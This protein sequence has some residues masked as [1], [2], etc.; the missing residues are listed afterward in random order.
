MVANHSAVAVVDD[1]AAVLDSI[2]FLLGVAGRKADA[3]RSAAAFLKDPTGRPACLILDQHMP[4]MTG[5]ELV[6]RLRSKGKQIP[7]LLMTELLSVALT[8]CAAQHGIYEIVEKPPDPDALLRF[9]DAHNRTQI[10]LTE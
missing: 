3:Y 9:V 6:A 7:V 2:S 8:R 4:Q 5:L 1:D 10:E